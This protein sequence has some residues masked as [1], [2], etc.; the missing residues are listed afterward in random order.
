MQFSSINRRNSIETTLLRDS[1][2]EE[3]DAT[4]TG[5][6]TASW[7]AKCPPPCTRG[8]IGEA[9]RGRRTNNF[10]LTDTFNLE[11]LIDCPKLLRVNNQNTN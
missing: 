5:V 9:Q 8:K 11:I 2:E 3:E 10:I 6:E 4:S 7:S 1:E